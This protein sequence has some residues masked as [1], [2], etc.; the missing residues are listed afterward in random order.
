MLF[1]FQPPDSGDENTERP[2]CTTCVGLKTDEDITI[3]SSICLTARMRK[4]FLSRDSCDLLYSYR[5]KN[6]ERDS[7]DRSEASE[8]KTYYH[9]FFDGTRYQEIVT[10]RGGEEAAKWDIFISITSDGFQ[11]FNNSAYDVWPILAMVENLH[12]EVRFLMRNAVPLAYVKGPKEATQLDTFMIPIV[13]E[14]RG[15]NADGGTSFEFWDGAVRSVQVH[16]LYMKG[17]SPATAKNAGT[18]GTNGKCPCRFC[19]I[20]CWR[21]QECNHEYYPSVI[22]I[23]EP[24]GG[25]GR[26]WRLKRLFNP[27]SLPMRRRSDVERIWNELD[28][29]SISAA[30]RRRISTETGIK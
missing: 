10:E 27:E 19:S 30:K 7:G 2:P 12:P 21:A 17:D 28:K 4:W 22:K 20:I 6:I 9:D 15:I 1:R 25:G 8:T 11:C 23:L 26:R 3:H 13:E 16:V 29:P 14:I 24:S 18:T 5:H